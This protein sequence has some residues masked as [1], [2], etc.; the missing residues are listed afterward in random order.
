MKK[1]SIRLLL[2][3]AIIFLFNTE[4]KSSW[5]MG[6]DLSY[7]N[8]GQDSFIIK[9]VMYRD[10]NG[11]NPCNANIT[12]KCKSTNQIITTATMP[13]TSTTDITSVCSN[14]CTRCQTGSC[15][16]P[17]GV[18][19]YEYQ[20]LVVLNTACCELILSYQMCCRNATITTGI[21]NKYFYI[22]A[23][24]NRCITPQNSSP[25]FRNEAL[26]LLCK[27]QD[28]QLNVGAYDTDGD[29]LA[30]EFAYP[31]E[32]HGSNIS[33][34]GQYDYDKAFYFYGFPNKNLPLP[35]GIHLN[36]STG[37]L[38]FRP[39]KIEQ[40]VMVINVSEFRNGVKIGEN[41]RDIQIIVINCPTNHSP[42]LNPTSTLNVTEGDTVN[43]TF[44][45][46]DIDVNDTLQIC[47][48]SSITNT[49]WQLN[50]SNYKHPIGTLKFY[51]DIT[52]L[53][54]NILTVSARDNA[55]PVYGLTSRAYKIYVHPKAEA[56]F[57]TTNNGC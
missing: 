21:A 11:I 40:T 15:S 26:N 9:L 31:L 14:S 42:K 22:E 27:D 41:R 50:T 39:T 7:T 38:S 32:G 28:Y 37:D 35:K 24:L 56:Q 57:S 54:L 23:T 47:W 20:K 18:E 36:P 19:K 45:T 43:Y 8:M 10:C 13:R 2:S 12:I 17:Y 48:D 16:F 6:G 33:Y 55:C 4:V 46:S 49:S 51:P 3:L 29:S 30:Y 44:S 25:T 34:S 1:L 53:G 5:F 52:N